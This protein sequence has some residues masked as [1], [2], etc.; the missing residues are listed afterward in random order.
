[1]KL[2]SLSGKATWAILASALV[3]S[4]AAASL[5]LRNDVRELAHSHQALASNLMRQLAHSGHLALLADNRAALRPIAQSILHTDPI[6]GSATVYDATGNAAVRAKRTVAAPSPWQLRMAAM[7]RAIASISLP[8]KYSTPIPLPGAGTSLAP[9]GTPRAGIGLATLTLSSAQWARELAG[10]ATR[11][12]LLGLVVFASLLLTTLLVAWLGGRPLNRLGVRLR[13]ITG[14]DEPTTETEIETSL[15]AIGERL[16]RSE[17]SARRAS[18]ALRDR[19]ITL[20]H[21]RQRAHDATRLRSDMLAGISHELRT[22]LA[23]ILGHTDTLS[24]SALDHEQQTQVTTIHSS[25]RHLLGLLD[26]VLEW[27]RMESGR[28]SIDEV[29]FNIA[30]TIEET[31]TL[32]APMAYEKNLELAHLVYQDVPARLRGDPLRFQQVLTN[33]V[34]NAIKF[35]DHGSVVVRA[36]LEQETDDQVQVRITV[37]DTGSGISTSDQARLFTLYERLEPTANR[38]GTGMGLA[39]SKHLLELMGGAIGVNST[40]ESGSE[41]Y[42][43]LPLRKALQ[44]DADRQTGLDL[45]GRCVW[46]LEPFAPARNALKHR[47]EAW[48]TTVVT[49]DDFSALQ[50]ALARPDTAFPT[51]DVLI[52][53]LA[54][55][56]T[57]A[58]ALHRL[59]ATHANRFPIITLVTSNDRILHRQLER[60]GAARSMPKA[61]P[62]LRL[63]REICAVLG[64]HQPIGPESNGILNGIKTLVA[65]DN[66]AGQHYLRTQLTNLGAQVALVGNGQAAIAAWQQGA[67]PLVFADDRMPG[68]DGPSVFQRIRTMAG[69]AAQPTLIGIT[70]NAMPNVRARFREAGADACLIKPFTADQIIQQV[71][72]LLNTSDARA[73]T[74]PTPDLTTD[75]ELAA[76][77]TKELPKQLA[78]VEAALLEQNYQRARE[79]VHTLHGTAAFYRLEALKTAA[80]GLEAILADNRLPDAAASNALRQAAQQ[81]QQQLAQGLEAY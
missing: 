56:A 69:A 35:T 74:P 49:I 41:F 62:Q 64:L 72:P 80:G 31:V 3:L 46:L 6:V 52:L 12:A 30:D 65:E 47:L 59:L 51:P 15:A 77:I 50:K 43:T 78:D 23:A 11:A 25:A 18:E 14:A 32:L 34:S 66:P 48:R 37:T 68:L 55:D 70:A 19:E 16:M 60:N 44:D 73:P 76:L 79:C 17:E 33:L 54:A 36:M 81:A 5:L 22:P 61:T 45:G 57:K 1:M 53:A 2:S 29:G 38:A 71:A 27:S 63:Y 58:A 4:V 21:A 26:S 20:D 75:P 39:I 10:A 28:T 7:A 24:A 40:P 42:F 67:F 9:F 8:Q 13:D